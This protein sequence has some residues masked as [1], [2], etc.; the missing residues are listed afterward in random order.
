MSNTNVTGVC[1]KLDVLADNGGPTLTHGLKDMSAAIDKGV[2]PMVVT[3]DQRL[4]PRS[5]G[6]AVDIGAFE[7]KPTDK[8]E[9][10][11]ASGFD[12]LCDQ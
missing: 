11:L 9:R 4:E 2:A 12:G 5:T 8:P 1:A 3:T 10:F 7:R 6:S